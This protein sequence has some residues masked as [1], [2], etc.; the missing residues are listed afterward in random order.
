MKRIAFALFAAAWAAFCLFPL[1]T[2]WAATASTLEGHVTTTSGDPIAGAEVRIQATLG[3]P[4]VTRADGSFTLKTAVPA[5]TVVTV[6][7]AAVDPE[8]KHPA[9]YNAGTQASV[10]DAGV[11]I[12]LAPIL[13][14]D[15]ADYS[16]GNPNECMVCHQAYVPDFLASP[17]AAAARNA[18]VRDVYDGSGTADGHGGF[19][20]KGAHPT[21]KG[22]CAECH[23]PMQSAKNPGDNTDLT[24]DVSGDARQ[25]GVSCDVCHKTV[26]ITNVKLPGVQGMTFHRGSPTDDARARHEA[27][28]GP[29]PDAIP[30]FGG[31]M[32][33]S[34]SPLHSQ[35]LLCAACHEDNNDADLDGDYLDEGS[36]PSE[37]SYSEWLASRYA[38]PG[39][40]YKTCQSCHMPPTGAT[41]VADQ[42]GTVTR[43]A[44][45]VHK[46]RFEGT[47]DDYVKN[48]AA[49]HVVARRESGELR[50][51]VAVTND[52]AGHDLPGGI[53]LRHAILLVNA[54]DDAGKALTF[55]RDGSSVV[56]DYAGVGDPSAGDFGGLP[57]KGFAKIFTDGTRE[58][59]FFT[60]ATGIASDTRIPAGA[61]D[62]SDYRFELPDGVN[63]VGVTA[64]LLYRRA[65]RSMELE[66]N[67]TLT[68]HGRE[69]PDLVG[70]DFGLL[71]GSSAVDVPAA[72]IDLAGA[73]VSLAK[74]LRI[75]L[76]AGASA[77]L[78]PGAVVS[79]S[80]ATGAFAE[81][82]QPAV[83]DGTGSKLTQKGS[84]G[85]LKIGQ[86]WQNGATR[87]L[88]IVNPDGSEG[89]IR[90]ERRGTRLVAVA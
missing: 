65:F 38:Q 51:S 6:T 31:V 83:V 28:F 53:F 5:G 69:N 11:S 40:D 82:S 21:L 66:K 29:L 74:G 67:W 78:E 3:E 64:K 8:T 25:F 80:D 61:T 18:W 87:F 77:T 12:A 49:L 68:G 27:I 56:P 10:G 37:E 76:A 71:M 79:L 30:N 41:V 84:I 32:R 59:V 75:R 7:A 57:G 1:V 35:S 55:V 42:Y 15:A 54:V 90:L 72:S 70:P 47:T 88:R 26:G 33:A 50:V 85:G 63:P 73:K 16:F 34:Y 36:V 22:D 43:D 58:G 52:R 39:V 86:Y 19:T 89:T 9:Y 2:E 81:F 4:A 62:W 48:S 23:A 17:H 46:H 45:Q 14:G 24:A 20:Y 13:A 60:E 44:S